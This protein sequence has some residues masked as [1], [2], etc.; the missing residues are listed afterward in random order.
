M[1]P[2]RLDFDAYADPPNS[3]ATSM[4]NMAEIMVGCLD[5]TEA[6][7]VAE[8]GA[9]AGD[10]T[11]LLADWAAQ[12]DARV[13]AIDP[14][15]QDPLVALDRDRTELELIRETSLQALPHLAP[16]DVV[17]IDG[18]HNYYT[19]AE[20][21]RLISE[22]AEGAELPLL[23]FHDVCWPHARRDDYFAPELIPEPYRQLLAGDG[24]GLHPGEAGLRP[25]GMPYRKSAAREGGAR[26]GVLTAAEDFVSGRDDLR[27]AVVPAFFGFGAIWHLGSPAAERLA[28][29]LDPWDRNPVLARLESNRVHQIAESHGRQVRIWAEQERVA[30]QEAV[31]RRLLGSSAFSIA[32]RLSRLRDR[33]GVA[34]GQSVVS[35]DEIRRALSG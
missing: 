20:E 1:T 17:V 11:R 13:L 4:A 27:L 25:G 28:A 15:P 14:S 9:Y 23:I 18:D 24:G 31:L 26:N 12:S 34:T 8:I 10:L 6:K 7:L 16:P 35:K 33:V 3:W 19:V 22:L 29:I 2:V 21:L 5:A 30:R 32:E